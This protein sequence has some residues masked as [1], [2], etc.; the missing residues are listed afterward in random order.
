MKKLFK[1]V[2]YACLLGLG[3]VG[4]QSDKVSSD[5]TEPKVS[6]GDAEIDFQFSVDDIAEAT[7]AEDGTYCYGIDKLKELIQEG[8][9]VASITVGEYDNGDY[10][11]ELYPG[12]LINLTSLAGSTNIPMVY[13][14]EGGGQIMTEPILFDVTEDPESYYIHQIS[15]SELDDPNDPSTGNVIF[16][17]ILAGSEKAQELGGAIDE[18]CLAGEGSPY[19]VIDDSSLYEKTTINAC[20]YCIKDEDAEAFGYVMWNIQFKNIVGV[21]FMVNICHHIT[22]K[23][24]KAIGTIE[25]ERGTLEGDVFTPSGES[26]SGTSVTFGDYSESREL[27]KIYFTDDSQIADDEEAYK[28]KLTVN[29]GEVIIQ[30]GNGNKS[31]ETYTELAME[32]RYFEAIVDMATLSAY[33][34][35]D[36]FDQ[37]LNYLHFWFCEGKDYWE[38]KETTPPSQTADYAIELP[39]DGSR[40]YNE[41]R[42]QLASDDTDDY[43]KWVKPITDNG[44]YTLADNQQMVTYNTVYLDDLSVFKIK[45]YE[46]AGTV[47]ILVYETDGTDPTNIGLG[48]TGVED[49]STVYSGTG[50]NIDPGYYHMII[51]FTDDAPIHSIE[52]VNDPT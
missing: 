19:F 32:P 13:I 45:T 15:I 7:R 29:S 3:V 44:N 42:V 50:F 24:Y 14:N 31:T 28:I 8:K 39:D 17:S 49:G 25:I 10:I 41:F 1:N 6:V 40:F 21:P 33:H 22:G 5:K 2:G 46:D 35:D 48:K 37:Q 23:D 20:V 36:A 16:T 30:E 27:S 47:Q 43:S 52:V 11:G 18:D 12:Q 34:E 26:Q 51:E 38:F 4:C 9:L